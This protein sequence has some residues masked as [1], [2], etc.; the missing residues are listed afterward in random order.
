MGGSNPVPTLSNGAVSIPSGIGNSLASVVAELLATIQAGQQAMQSANLTNVKPLS[1]LNSGTLLADRFS[2]QADAVSQLLDNHVSILEALGPAFIEAE[3][4]YQ[5][6]TE[7]AAREFQAIQKNAQSGTTGPPPKYNPNA[8]KAPSHLGPPVK[9]VPGQNGVPNNHDP[10][11]AEPGSSLSL[12][13]MKTFSQHDQN[14]PAFEQGQTWNWLGNGL[15]TAANDFMTGLQNASSEWAGTGKDAALAA[16][17]AYAQSLQQL[18]TE[19]GQVGNALEFAVQQ[20][21]QAISAMAA[22]MAAWDGKNDNTATAARNAGINII[23]NTY[24]PGVTWSS[25]GLPPALTPAKNPMA[26][27]HKPNDHTGGGNGGDGGPSGSGSGTNASGSA[28]NWNTKNLISTGKGGGGNSDGGP[29]SSYGAG[30]SGGGSQYHQSDTTTNSPS[31]TNNPSGTDSSYYGAAGGRGGSQGSQG[32]EYKSKY[33]SGS[34]S[35]ESEKTH[36]GSGIAASYGADAS[37]TLPVLG[38]G[39]AYMF[40]SASGTSAISIRAGSTSGALGSGSI[41]YS[42]S[43]FGAA[44]SGSFGFGGVSGSG[45]GFGS[46]IGELEALATSFVQQA[47]S[48]APQLLQQLFGQAD[49]KA[50][51]DATQRADVAGNPGS[52]SDLSKLLGAGGGGS[53][54]GGGFG[55]GG[56][57]PA[58]DAPAYQ[59]PSNL[60][61]RATA[62]AFTADDPVG[63]AGPI[64]SGLDAA[65]GGMPMGG[66]GGMGSGGT[67]GGGGQSKEHKTAE[68]LNSTAN[69]DEAFGDQFRA[70]RSVMDVP[71]KGRRRKDEDG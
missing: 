36:K 62:A 59:A 70:T 53:G 8:T 16:C 1:S 42:G 68:N 55:T 25:E 50:A 5:G 22:A 12:P 30:G 61:P 32:S 14:V 56:A 28:P 39:G 40:G 65:P 54:G 46:F 52:M 51:L 18:A 34:G 35:D 4:I 37:G 60:F 41:Y 44:G 7:A 24:D 3:K 20:I 26:K 63:T 49:P 31:N 13:D 11:S 43:G 38:S 67:A 48:F 2:K 19:I 21:D 64:E 58:F 71:V 17:Q 6:A 57:G 29:G 66:M 23:T 15:G 33:G 45:T 9:F 47:A 10:V 27:T 69:L